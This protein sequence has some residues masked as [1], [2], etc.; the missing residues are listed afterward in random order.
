MINIDNITKKYGRTT[1]LKNMSYQFRDRGITC[2]LGASGCGKT[3]LLN[4]LAGFDTDYNGNITVC[5]ENITSMS[6][7]D[8]YKYRKNH[9]GF[10]FQNYHLINGYTVLENILLAAEIN[11]KS[12]KENTQKALELL[13]KLGIESKTND[14]TEN[15]SGGQKQRV[16]IAR[17]LI[18]DPQI[19]LADEPTGALDRGTSSQIMDILKEIAM[20]RLVIVITHDKKICDWADEVISIVD[21]KIEVI[22]SKQTTAKKQE[23]KD[24]ITNKSKVSIWKRAVKNFKIHILRYIAVSL[25]VAIGISSF[26]VSFSSRNMMEQ[27]IEDFKE[28]H[29]AFNNG[30]VKVDEKQNPFDI[31]SGDERIENVYYQYILKD[32]SIA[33]E[34]TKV[35][36]IEK[37]PMPKA[38][39][40]MSYG[41]MPRYGQNEIA[42][43]PSVAKKLSNNIQT[44]I[45]NNIVMKY[46]DQNINLTISGIYDAGYDD[47]FISSDIE[48]SLY[49]SMEEEPPF[50]ISYDVKNFSDI[51]SVS[52]WLKEQNIIAKTAVEQVAALENTFHN[53]N[54]LFLILSILV[55]AIGLFICIVLLTKLTNARFREV[56]LLAALGYSKGRIREIL[57]AENILLSCT[58]IIFSTGMLFGINYVYSFVLGKTMMIKPSQVVLTIILT[59]STVVLVSTVASL[60]L[61]KTEPAE[62]LRK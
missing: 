38:T 23:Q 48:Q 31:L 58:A 29:T 22:S 4:L 9:I 53:L 6:G 26:A 41:V 25:A 12:Q 52:N 54:R 19:L 24:K 44:L 55:L 20:D 37:I 35:D 60:K 51:V 40:N 8:L 11:G 49:D 5:N 21:G 27:S 32:I 13:T 7:V 15:L 30:Y 59:F 34:N 3:T 18:N 46:R 16:A 33:F 56:G 17:A 14:K 57:F 42:I 1:I 62:A 10:V 45:G 43:N 47:F 50:S 39:G 36:F 2:I 28:K 61:I